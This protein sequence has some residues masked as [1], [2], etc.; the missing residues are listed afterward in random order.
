MKGF[1]MRAKGFSFPYVG[2]L[3]CCHSEAAVTAF[4]PGCSFDELCIFE[5]YTTVPFG[6]IHHPGDPNRLLDCYLDPDLG[7]DRAF[8]SLHIPYELKFWPRGSEASDAVA[9]LLDWLNKGPVVLGPLNMGDLN[10]IFHPELVKCVDHYVIALHSDRDSLWICD[11]EGFPMVL[12]PWKDL[13]R[14]W[15]G[16]AIIEGRGAFVMRRVEPGS[17]LRIDGEGLRQTLRLAADNLEAARRSEL[18]GGRCLTEIA[19][20][21][22]AS[23]GRQLSSLQRGLTYAIPTRIQRCVLAAR[24]VQQATS[25]MV[26]SRIEQFEPRILSILDA[27]IELYGRILARVLGRDTFDCTIPK[28]IGDLEEELADVF[29]EMRRFL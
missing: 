16:D 6:I 21:L 27:Q 4:F 9:G 19:K 3:T 15:R 2:N 24:V 17:R 7:L 28:R 8:Q 12:L 23:S 22:F 25:L 1:V 13:V 26:C 20:G 5:A 14:A 29:A 11:T 18:G 10:Y